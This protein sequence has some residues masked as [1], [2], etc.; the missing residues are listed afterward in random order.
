MRRWGRGQTFSQRMKVTGLDR[1]AEGRHLKIKE[2]QQTSQLQNNRQGGCDSVR[3]RAT[4]NLC[5]W[6]QLCSGFVTRC[7]PVIPIFA[8]WNQNQARIVMK[9]LLRTW[10]YKNVFSEKT[11]SERQTN[12]NCPLLPQQQFKKLCRQFPIIT[13]STVFKVLLKINWIELDNW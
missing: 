7:R 5:T 13:E 6:A 1:M 4:C 3:H 9:N 11:V 10:M 2:L 12:K 8:K